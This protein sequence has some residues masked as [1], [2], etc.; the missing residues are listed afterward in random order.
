MMYAAYKLNKQG[1]NIQPWRTIVI[2]SKYPAFGILDK[3]TTGQNLTAIP[4][5][6]SFG[7]N[8]FSFRES[9]FYITFR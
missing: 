6:S 3:L 4:D 1:D 5:K 8:F 2:K 9:S 7:F